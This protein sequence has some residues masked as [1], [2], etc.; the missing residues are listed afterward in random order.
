MEKAKIKEIVVEK[1]KQIVITF[2]SFFWQVK[3]AT[4]Q[5]P[6]SPPVVRHDNMINCIIPVRVFRGI[7]YDDELNTTEFF[8]ATLNIYDNAI[9]TL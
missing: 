4:N 9:N 2:G 5:S 7:F 1:F 6:K 3:S 8:Y